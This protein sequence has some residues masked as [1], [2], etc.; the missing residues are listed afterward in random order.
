M[1]RYIAIVWNWRT[2]RAQ[3]DAAVL[4]EAAKARRPTWLLTRDDPGLWILEPPARS[5]ADEGLMVEGGR[6]VGVAFDAATRAAVLDSAALMKGACRAL[7]SMTWG[8]YVA[9]LHHRA[10][11]CTYVARD[12]SGAMGCFHGRRGWAFAFFGDERDEDALDLDESDIDWDYIARRLRNNR[13]ISEDTGVRGI[14][15]LAPGA[16]A[17][18][19]QSRIRISQVWSKEEIAARSEAA[20]PAHERLRGAVLESCNA[21]AGC[22]D[23]AIIRLSGG[24]DSAIVAGALSGRVAAM[25]AVNFATTDAEG[26]ERAFARL[27]AER[28]GLRLAEIVRNPGSVSLESETQKAIGCRPPLWL[29]DAETDVRESELAAHEHAQVYFSGRGG[30]NV[31][32]RNAGAHALIDLVKQKGAGP[33]LFGAL[34]AHAQA[35]RVSAISLARD[36]VRKPQRRTLLAPAWLSAKALEI[37]PTNGEEVALAPGKQL[38]LAMIE[39]RLNY[40]DVR[41]HADYIYPLISQPV[42]ETCLT[43]PTFVLAPPGQADRALARRALGDLTHRRSCSAE[44]RDRL[45]DI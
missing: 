25:S 11:A 31:F 45:Q 8:R 6:I 37:T 7:F 21:W 44:G 35:N 4:I 33:A 16:V 22:F 34:F 19:G 30:D 29:A 12:P 38:H 23:R 28:N 14:G 17:C 5:R 1:S 39:D 20:A 32:F 13:L 9:F 3:A 26:D 27:A 10:D 18:V 36:L 24:L 15:E 2:D 41:N 43:L 40:F 42:I